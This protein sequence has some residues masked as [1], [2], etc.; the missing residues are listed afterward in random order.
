[1]TEVP[2]KR[3]CCGCWGGVARSPDFFPHRTHNSRARSMPALAADCGSNASLAST[4][5]QISS[6]RMHSAMSASRTLV[7][8]EDACPQISVRQ[9]SGTPPVS[10]STEAMPVGIISG[11][12]RCGGVNARGIRFSRAASTRLRSS[13]AVEIM[14]KEQAVIFALYS[15]MD[16]ILHPPAT[17]VKRGKI[18]RNLQIRALKKP[19]FGLKTASKLARQGPC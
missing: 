18:G 5:A 1:M 16:W 3:C 11:V 17:V 10:A 12:E 8:P 9:P 6:R 4:S 19:R 14:A 2:S 13:E 7:R 15:P